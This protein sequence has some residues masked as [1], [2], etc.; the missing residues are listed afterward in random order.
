[1]NSQQHTKNDVPNVAA[2][3]FIPNTAHGINISM[4]WEVGATHNG[5]DLCPDFNF[6]ART[7]IINLLCPLPFRDDKK[8]FKCVSSIVV[9]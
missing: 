5:T 1:M 9:G 4:F 3:V 2:S 8:T 7:M 6:G